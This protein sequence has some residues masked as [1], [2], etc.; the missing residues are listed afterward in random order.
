MT[1]S[2]TETSKFKLHELRDQFQ[3]P[4]QTQTAKFN[5]KFFNS[6]KQ[7]WIDLKSSYVKDSWLNVIPAIIH[8]SWI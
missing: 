8:F 2:E 1:M 5:F 4:V 3:I 7:N 6:F